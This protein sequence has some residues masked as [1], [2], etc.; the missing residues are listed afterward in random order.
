MEGKIRNMIVSLL[1]LGFG[2]IWIAALARDKASIQLNPVKGSADGNLPPLSGATGWINSKLLTRADLR[3][4]VVLVEFWTYTCVNW[5]RTLPYVR[6]W[7]EKYRQQGLI[8]I[9]VHTPEFSFEKDTNNVRRAIKELN[10]GFP[11]AIDNNYA[12]W[13]AFRNEY[14]PALYFIDARGRIRHYHF[15]EGSY[16]TSERVIQQ[17]LDE[18]GVA[19]VPQD[20]V[21]LTLT[22]AEA[23]ADL[24]N[25]ESPE[26]YLDYQRTHNF[27]SPGGPVADRQHVYFRPE[28][29]GLNEWA[30]AGDWTMQPEADRSNTSGGLLV[31]RFHARDLN[32]V[33]GPA[34]P[35]GSIRFRVRI[36]GE[37]PG[38]GHGA[39]I[40]GSGEGTITEQRMYQLIHQP[41]AITDRTIEIEFLNSGVEVFDFTFG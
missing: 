15:G 3:G 40:V 26:T 31:C 13:F 7:A 24:A 14:W 12:V 28:T 22:G 33:M 16:D 20:L 29:L 34:I 38:D 1:L 30:L 10:I 2:G 41:G 18:M 25:L 6:A 11:V 36:D 23:P 9:G 37:P 4:K 35:G 5:R 32:L 27:V 19:G 39:D 8:V 17:L 21:A